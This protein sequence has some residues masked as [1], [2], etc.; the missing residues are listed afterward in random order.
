MK[1][2]FLAAMLV[3]ISTVN[4]IACSAEKKQDT[5]KQPEPVT[6]ES[7]KT[8]AENDGPEGEY[9]IEFYHCKPEDFDLYETLITKFEEKYPNIKVTQTCPSDPNKVFV[10]RV[11]SNDLPD[12]AGVTALSSQIVEMMNEGIFMH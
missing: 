3:V 1:R 8:T 10:T 6:Q 9:E 7:E 12:I 2:K 11:A 5:S 4:L